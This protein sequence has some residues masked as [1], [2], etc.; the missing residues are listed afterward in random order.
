[1]ESD[2]DL[3]VS[4]L[5]FNVA[6]VNGEIS[7]AVSCILRTRF[8]I[9]DLPFYLTETVFYIFRGK[10]GVERNILRVLHRANL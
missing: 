1:M 2:L 5:S 9:G 8:E 3:T 4:V 6:V 10:Y 7:S